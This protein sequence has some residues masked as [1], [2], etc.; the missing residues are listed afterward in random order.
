[1]V[2]LPAFTAITSPLLF[3]FA[4]FGLLD[5]TVN[6]NFFVLDLIML[7]FLLLTYT[8]ALLRS[9]IFGVAS[10]ALT[11]PNSDTVLV[12]ANAG[13]AVAGTLVAVNASARDAADAFA[14]IFFVFVFLFLFILFFS[15]L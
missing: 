15:S 3:T 13:S 6:F 10:F 12:A 8:V 7:N 9:L 1:M 4:T 14:I 2:A 5:F 11:A